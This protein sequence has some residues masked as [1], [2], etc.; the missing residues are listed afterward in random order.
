[1][2]CTMPG[3]YSPG[4]GAQGSGHARQIFHQLSHASSYSGSLILSV[5]LHPQP[6]RQTFLAWEVIVQMKTFRNHASQCVKNT[7]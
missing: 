6:Q 7:E 2:V 1:M 4:G 5:E 3:L